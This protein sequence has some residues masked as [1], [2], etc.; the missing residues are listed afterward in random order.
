MLGEHL[1]YD[2][3]LGGLYGVADCVQGLDSDREVG[4]VETSNNGG[5]DV[6][7]NEGRYDLGVVMTGDVRETPEC[8]LHQSV[9]LCQ[10]K[11]V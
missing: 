11:T 8:V 10:Q 3:R 1:M 9:I 4:R 6:M 7:R 5:K 2:Q